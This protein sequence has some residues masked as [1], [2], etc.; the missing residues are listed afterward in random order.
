MFYVCASHS[1]PSEDVIRREF[2]LRNPNTEIID[3]KLIFEEVAVSTY[4]VECKDNTSEQ[5]S[6]KQITLHQCINWDWKIDYEEC[7]GK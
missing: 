7:N 3:T 5:I 4:R 2:I 6:V 1:H